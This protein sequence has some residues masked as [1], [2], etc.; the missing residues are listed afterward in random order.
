[1]DARIP[2]TERCPFR[3]LRPAAE[4]S[5]AN[6]LSS[7]ASPVFFIYTRRKK[8]FSLINID[9]ENT[10][11]SR[12]IVKYG[13]FYFCPSIWIYRI[14]PCIFLF[15]SHSVNIQFPFLKRVFALSHNEMFWLYREIC[16]LFVY[17]IHYRFFCLCNLKT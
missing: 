6:F 16:F 2:P 11:W 14:C 17:E 1:M 13:Y 15:V 12:K 9:Q 10:N 4:A 7:S 8:K 5:L 3:F